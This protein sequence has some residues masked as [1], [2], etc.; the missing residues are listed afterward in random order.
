MNLAEFDQYIEDWK[1]YVT[2]HQAH[3]ADRGPTL[4]ESDHCVWDI[5]FLEQGHF[6]F[7]Q[8]DANRGQRIVEVLELG[9]ADNG[10]GDNRLG[11]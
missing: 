1:A 10:R 8:P 4:I 3:P 5:G 9:G 7:G 6:V 2:S 11:Q